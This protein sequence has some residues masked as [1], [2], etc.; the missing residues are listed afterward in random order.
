MGEAVEPFGMCSY[1]TSADVQS[2]A[3]PKR[4][5]IHDNPEEEEIRLQWE[6]E[7]EDHQGAGNPR[8]PRASLWGVALT[9]AVATCPPPLKPAV[10]GK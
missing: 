1:W 8:P 9:E 5:R 4:E 10:R 7:D 2:L 3:A 6:T